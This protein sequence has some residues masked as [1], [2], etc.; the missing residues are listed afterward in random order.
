MSW[1]RHLGRPRSAERPDWRAEP[2]MPGAVDPER[3]PVVPPLQLEPSL[4]HSG[5]RTPPRG[6]GRAD[7][8]GALSTPAFAGTP[9]VPEVYSPGG[10]GSTPA[11]GTHAILQQPTA[12][13]RGRRQK[14]NVA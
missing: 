3:G 2:R 4:A 10:G 9:G 5:A 12:Q 14:Q 13:E 11:L 8:D 7:R 6:L 1:G